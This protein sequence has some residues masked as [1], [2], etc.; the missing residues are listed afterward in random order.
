MLIFALLIAATNPNIPACA[1]EVKVVNAVAPDI[2]KAD[3]KPN[4]T[5]RV[6]VSVDANGNVT[7]AKVMLSSGSTAIDNDTLVAAKKSTYKPA[8]GLDCKPHAGQYDFHIATG[9]H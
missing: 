1:S 8:I 3:Y 7:D 6:L 4:V 5:A 9:P 2:S